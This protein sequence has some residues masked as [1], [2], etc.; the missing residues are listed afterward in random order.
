MIRYT[1]HLITHHRIYT[2]P[3]L[4]YTPQSDIEAASKLI[5]RELDKAK[6]PLIGLINNAGVAQ[7]FPLEYHPMKDL[8]S[9]YD[10]SE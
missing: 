5:L 4:T 6:I 10:V 7:K 8:R 2:K 1:S 9:M 3:H